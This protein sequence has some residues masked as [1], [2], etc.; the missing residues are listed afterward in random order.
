MTTTSMHPRRPAASLHAWLALLLTAS[1]L[2]G[3]CATGGAQ[4]RPGRAPQLLDPLTA[5]ERVTAEKLARADGRAVELLGRE[6]R[7]VTADFLALKDEKADVATRHA[8]LLFA[9]P[10]GSYGVRV[11]VRLDRDPAVVEVSRVAASS[12]PMTQADIDEAWKIAL[13]DSAYAARLGRDPA[14]VRVE[15]LRLYTEDRDDPCFAGRCFYLIVR[16]GAFYV[17]DA[18]VIVDLATRRLVPARR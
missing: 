6:A 15:A 17:S 9:V 5:D 18:S 10:A 3:G 8:D 7:L 2:V 13:A 14:S 1:G 16:E 12:V 4:T 11:I